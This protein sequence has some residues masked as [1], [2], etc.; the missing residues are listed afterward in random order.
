MFYQILRLTFGKA[1]LSRQNAENGNSWFA[2]RFGKS[3]T[4]YRYIVYNNIIEVNVPLCSTPNILH[5]NQLN[6][7]LTAC[8]KFTFRNRSCILSAVWVLFRFFHRLSDIYNHFLLGFGSWIFLESPHW[9][10]CSDVNQESRGIFKKFSS[11]I[12]F[13]LKLK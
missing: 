2:L 11:T 8:N 7:C 4:Y 10:H 5:V 6:Y 1:H 12:F 13:G 9:H 3:T